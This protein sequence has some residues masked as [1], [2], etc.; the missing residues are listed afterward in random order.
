VQYKS[1]LAMIFNEIEFHVNTSLGL[2]GGMHPLH[3]P[4]VRAWFGP[5]NLFNRRTPIPK[6]DDL[7]IPCQRLCH[8]SNW[9]SLL[10]VH[11]KK[12]LWHSFCVAGD[13]V[14]LF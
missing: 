9:W 5:R 6:Y 8:Y 14:P 1:I 2:V 7:W 10:F 4:C 11:L 12:I 3:P 13:L